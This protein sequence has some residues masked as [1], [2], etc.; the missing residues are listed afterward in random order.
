MFVLVIPLAASFLF[1]NPLLDAQRQRTVNRTSVPV[2]ATVLSAQV[3]QFHGSHGAIHYRPEVKYQYKVGEK[4]FRS[5]QLAALSAWG[6]KDWANAVVAR[7]N[8]NMVAK[9]YYQPEDPSHAILLRIC[10]FQP[11][12]EMLQGA[13]C[14]ACSFFLIMRIWQEERRQPVP[15]AMGGFEI[16]PVSGERQRL[17]VAQGCTSL[18]YGLGGLTV[19]H[20]FLSRPGPYPEG[21][22]VCFGVFAMLGLIPL[23]RLVRHLRLN[24][25][26]EE[27]RLFVKQ[28]TTLRPSGRDVPGQLDWIN[29]DLR[30]DCDVAGGPRYCVRFP[31]EVQADC[32][33]VPEPALP[34]TARRRGRH[35]AG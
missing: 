31:I 22:L 23:S 2:E 25:N 15:A 17:L 18:W 29:W 7:H 27:A 33:T 28:P 6:T 32:A 4:T 26:L 35:S 13:F 1:V 3:T 19:V 14:A 9:A 30:L 10:S 16:F 34:Q 12:F 5:E 24:H 21:Q 20:Y 8:T 11:Y